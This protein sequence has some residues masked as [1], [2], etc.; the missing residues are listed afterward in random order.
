VELLRPW[1]ERFT[2]ALNR[3]LPEGLEIMDATHIQVVAGVKRRSLQ[4]IARRARY[5]VD[6]SALTDEERSE[7]R[8]IIASFERSE[9][10]VVERSFWTP[11]SSREIVDWESPSDPLAKTQTAPTPDAAPAAKAVRTVDLRKAILRVD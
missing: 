3:V 8:R 2:E 9:T 6:L 10:C 5:E 4:A 7:M 1:S 11:Q